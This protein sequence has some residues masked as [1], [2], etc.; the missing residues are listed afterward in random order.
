MPR[1]GIIEERIIFALRQ[2]EESK[3]VGDICREIGFPSKPSTAG[4]GDTLGWI[5]T[6]CGNCV[7]RARRTAS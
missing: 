7:N 5:L 2:A 3:K 4:S 1:Q 6:N